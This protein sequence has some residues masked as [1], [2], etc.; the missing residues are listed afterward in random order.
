MQQFIEQL[1]Q[2]VSHNTPLSPGKLYQFLSNKDFSELDYQDYL[3]P[4]NKSGYSKNI[5]QLE[6]IEIAIL[7]WPPESASAIHK[8]DGFF[9]YVG[10]LKGSAT[11]SSY[12]HIGK[13]LSEIERTNVHA[14]AMF[15]EFDGEIHKITNKSKAPLHTIH[16]YYPA[17]ADLDG[18][19]IYSEEGKIGTLNKEATAA[20]WNQEA[21][22]FHT[23]I[24]NAFEFLP[25]EKQAASHFLNFE[26]P[27]PTETQIQSDLELYYS[28]QA[29]SYDELDIQNRNRANYLNTINQLSSN[30]LAEIEAKRVLHIACGTG[31]RA[32]EIKQSSKLDYQIIGVDMNPKMSAL[33]ANNVDQIFNERFL[34]LQESL[35]GEFEAIFNLYAFGHLTNQKNRE[36]LVAKVFELLKPGG[37]FHVDVFNLSDASEW[38]P[39]IK[40]LSNKLHL[41]D[42]GYQEGDAFYRR[43]HGNYNTYLHYFSKEEITS[44]L[45]NAGFT[46]LSIDVIGYNQQ[47]GELLSNENGKY[48]IVAEKPN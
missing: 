3:P 12:A 42:Y 38:G 44:L 11:N 23:V 27:R 17:L 35:L 10:V 46:I 9:G 18:L 32:K 31:R 22:K 37:R 15:Y 28:E 21:D 14:G 24:E 33:A 2:F 41:L 30:S 13:E 26:I 25:F 8:H 6:P 1:N 29:S 19:K 5:L 40:R 48:F 7:N 45:E 20:D 36:L 34:N 43:K 39:E 4:A 16:I 47:S